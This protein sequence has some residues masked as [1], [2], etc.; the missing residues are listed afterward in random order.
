[1]AY[2]FCYFLIDKHPDIMFMQFKSISFASCRDSNV[3]QLYMSLIRSR[4]IPTTT[5]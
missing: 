4:E 2:G 1:M 3:K 5:L